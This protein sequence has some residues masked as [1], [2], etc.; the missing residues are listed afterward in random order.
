MSISNALLDRSEGKCELCFAE[1]ELNGYLVPPKSSEESENQIA[2]C[3]KCQQEITEA[4]TLDVNHWRCL[5]ES[6]WSQVP[7]VQVVTYR[8]LD[9]LSA[10]PWAQDLKGMLYLD[11]KTMEWVQAKADA[12]LVHKDSNGHVLQAGDTVTL[13]QDL[14][15]KG[16]SLTAKR[17]TAVRRI[18]LDPNNADYIEG[19]VDG[20]HIVI[21][22]QYVKKSN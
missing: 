1:T 7:A 12:A 6:M 14:N 5:N 19:K 22:T 8:L 9:R 3:S 18:R 16:S 2:V 10:E 15:V 17:G 11:D 21:L 13:I 20:Q 4:E